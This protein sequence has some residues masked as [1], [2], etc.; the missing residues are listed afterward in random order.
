MELFPPEDPFLGQYFRQREGDDDEGALADPLGAL[1]T[2][3]SDAVSRASAR[4]AAAAPAAKAA[5]ESAA[6]TLSEVAGIVSALAKGGGTLELL[7][8][9]QH[10]TLGVFYLARRHQL[11]RSAAPLDGSSVGDAALLHEL[12]RATDLSDAVYPDR[13]ADV[14]AR[15]KLLSEGDVLYAHCDAGGDEAGFFIARD[16]AAKKIFWVVHGPGAGGAGGAVAQLPGTAV[17]LP[18]GGYGHA[19]M[20]RAALGLMDAHLSRVLDALA[21][22][23]KYDLCIVGHST[24]AGIGALVARA[25]TANPD[26]SARLGGAGI[27]AICVAPTPCVSSDV[28][29]ALGGYVKSLVMRYDLVPR[30]SSLSVEQLRRELGGLDY[31]ALLKEDLMG[32]EIVR[33]AVDATAAAAAR[34]RDGERDALGRAH[35]AAAGIAAAVASDPRV[36]TVQ[37]FASDKIRLASDAVTGQVT[38]L[39]KLAAETADSLASRIDRVLAEAPAP[40]PSEAEG[41]AA[42][43]EGGA[44]AALG[45]AAAR[46]A[47]AAAAAAATAAD[48]ALARPRVREALGWVSALLKQAAAAAAPAAAPAPAAAGAVPAAA[49][50]AA[51]AAAARAGEEASGQGTAKRAD[52]PLYVPGRVYWLRPVDEALPD[53]HQSFELVDAGTDPRFQRIVLRASM[54][55]DHQPRAARAALADALSRLGAPAEAATAGA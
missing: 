53:E 18:G 45:G 41:G 17:E 40:A 2:A 3:V 11:E 39:E 27:T 51:P 38:A 42:A 19:G 48:A 6:Q 47:A 15:G 31:T 33:R 54:L 52:V 24:G 5:A 34:V 46:A 29:A 36:Q 20:W 1:F 35:A 37:S 23:P 50:A 22:H 7:A 25:L 44:G 28:A 32:S 4:G 9:P 10:A 26:L 14:L 12:L 16:H 43:A 49:A 8:H 13:Y 21:A 55:A 30:L